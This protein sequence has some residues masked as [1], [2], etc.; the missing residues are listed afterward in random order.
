MQQ[1]DRLEKLRYQ[2][3]AT[4]SARCSNVALQCSPDGF[5]RNKI[6]RI[7]KREIPGQKGRENGRDV[8]WEAVRGWTGDNGGGGKG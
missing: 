3:A 5:D 7:M 2:P 6:R 8:E 1:H 4:S